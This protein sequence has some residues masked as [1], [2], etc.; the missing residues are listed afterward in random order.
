M[1][2]KVN[3]ER[4]QRAELVF[5]QEG[6][7]RRCLSRDRCHNLAMHLFK[8]IVTGVN[9]RFSKLLPVSP[10]LIPASKT[11]AWSAPLPLSKQKVVPKLR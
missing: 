4:W 8:I 7:V 10:A 11:N 2:F 3:S 5:M 1:M 6:S 9:S